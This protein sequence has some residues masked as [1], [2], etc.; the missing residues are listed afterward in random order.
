MVV[1]RLTE[2]E[3]E[4]LAT[5]PKEVEITVAADTGAVANVVHPDELPD[6]VVPGCVVIVFLVCG[7]LAK[8]SGG[9]I[10]SVWFRAMALF[11]TPPLGGIPSKV[12]NIIRIN[13]SLGSKILLPKMFSAF[14]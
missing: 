3:C 1:A 4:L 14:S 9:S 6:G 8:R 5:S 11:A 2:D 10:A 7:V 13:I 12:F